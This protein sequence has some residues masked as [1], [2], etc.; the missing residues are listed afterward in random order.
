M[1]FNL[2]GLPP[3]LSFPTVDLLKSLGHLTT[4]SFSAWIVPLPQPW[5]SSTRSSIFCF[6]ENWFLNPEAYSDL[7]LSLCSLFHFVTCYVLHILDLCLF[8][9]KA[10]MS[11]F[12]FYE[13]GAAGDAWICS[14]CCLRNHH[15]L[16][17][18]RQQPSSSSQLGTSQVQR[19]VIGFCTQEMIS[20]C[21]LS[22][23]LIWKL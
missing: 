10:L 19:S 4:Y 7:I 6:P 16:S 13:M 21:R 5:C 17:Y 2:H 3:I 9:R 18:L 23:V 12:S 20:R 15:Q 8:I 11:A 1:D 22:W 14:H